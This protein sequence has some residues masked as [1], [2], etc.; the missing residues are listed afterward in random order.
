MS[1]RPLHA[2]L[3]M[4][5]GASDSDLLTENSTTQSG[6]ASLED[7]VLIYLKDRIK[8]HDRQF[9]E[10]HELPLRYDEA[11]NYYVYLQQGPGVLYDS[12]MNTKFHRT[13]LPDGTRLVTWYDPD[14]W[15]DLSQYGGY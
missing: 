13:Y 7:N 15:E 10:L 14:M 12:D 5:S 11:N 2:C 8:V 1:G 4:P 6:A 9:K 3:S